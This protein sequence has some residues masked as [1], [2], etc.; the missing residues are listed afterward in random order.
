MIGSG[1]PMSEIFIKKRA[2]AKLYMILS[3]GQF[4]LSHEDVFRGRLLYKE[5]LLSAYPKCSYKL[6][7]LSLSCFFLLF[8]SVFVCFK[9]FYEEC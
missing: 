3:L 4:G 7:L 1:K 2:N 9:C 5:S 8:H 6:P